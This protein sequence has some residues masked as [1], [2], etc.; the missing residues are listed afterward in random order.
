MP[1]YI[2]IDQYPDFMEKNIDKSYESQKIIGIMYRKCK[3]I[4]T[5]ESYYSDPI[6]I[7]QSLLIE[8]YNEFIE[9]ANNLYQ[10]YR[11]EMEI[12]LKNSD[13]RQESELFVG[14]SLSKYHTHDDDK[15]SFKLA[16]KYIRDLWDHIRQII[17]ND[18]NDK[19][20]YDKNK[21]LLKI[22]LASAFYF[23]AY[24]S[25]E[26]RYQKIIS[27]AWILED[28]LYKTNFVNR[29]TFSNNFINHFIHIKYQH[30]IM[31]R[32]MKKISLCEKL[33][34]TTN[35]TK[36]IMIGLFGLILF[37]SDCEIEIMP[38]T[39][40]LSKCYNILDY[41]KK[42]FKEEKF[43]L[44]DF[45]E[46]KLMLFIY[47]R[48][49]LFKNPILWPILY[50]LMHF[51]KIDNL[52]FE[53]NLKVDDFIQLSFTYFI[54]KKFVKNANISQVTE[55]YN[56][57]NNSNEHL[58]R[59]KDWHITMDFLEDEINTVN[60]N[61]GKILLEFYKDNSFKDDTFQSLP[62]E[63]EPILNTLNYEAKF[64]LKSH[65][66]KLLNILSNS[67]DIKNVWNQ[68]FFARKYGSEK[69]SQPKIIQN[70][71]INGKKKLSIEESSLFLFTYLHNHT[72]IIEFLNDN[73][74]E[75][76]HIIAKSASNNENFSSACYKEF[77]HHSL[78]QLNKAVENI[79]PQSKFQFRLK[80]GSL[81]LSNL[82]R[83]SQ[84]TFFEL[85]DFLHNKDDS[86]KSNQI[87]TLF[88]SKINIKNLDTFFVFN[89]FKSKTSQEYIVYIES[90]QI[91]SF[92]NNALL[93]LKYDSN[94]QFVKI[95]HTLSNWLCINLKN[96]DNN[97]DIR[98]TFDSK[99]QLNVNSFQYEFDDVICLGENFIK[100]LKNGIIVAEKNVLKLKKEFLDNSV[101][102][103]HFNS[104]KYYG[105]YENNWSKI[106]EYCKIKVPEDLN[107]DLL[108]NVKIILNDLNEYSQFGDTFTIKKSR[109]E[110]IVG[111][112]IDLVDRSDYKDYINLMWYLSKVFDK[113]L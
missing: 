55:E 21:D 113:I 45:D 75:F 29:D 83:E 106:F 64:K 101:F 32:Y 59:L 31:T 11:T 97:K 85:D 16:I 23:V 15:Q 26:N 63:F 76:S 40:E 7:N 72:D 94:L 37:Q 84:L 73:N 107:T 49:I 53:S 93:R 86:L 24:S 89:D 91:A 67:L 12:I 87:Q 68:H 1:S 78:K 33:S 3:K 103:E 109:I 105:D 54:R 60:K 70:K 57:L 99:H 77:F 52:F 47:F 62:N 20:K 92:E 104:R 38:L 5:N 13:C 35:D 96:I 42:C 25:Y 48:Q 111:L 39:N 112:K 65:C 41:T 74:S 8:G 9:Y 10:Y 46:K 82:K 79:Q 69:K 2:K 4:V 88:Y 58:Y 22:K 34:K 43:D 30:K 44:I 80:F 19:F 14:I 108:S 102:V 81:Y 27:F 90:N 6:E 51:A 17:N 71:L 50:T 95:E 98:F 18:L 56:K 61:I 110:L 100:I 66:F 36:L 28:Y